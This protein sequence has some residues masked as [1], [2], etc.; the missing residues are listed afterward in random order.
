MQPYV[1]RPDAGGVLTLTKGDEVARI[2]AIP[3]IGEGRVIDAVEVLGVEHERLQSYAQRAGEIYRAMCAG[4]TPETINLVAGHLFVDGALL[5]AV[6]GS[7]RLL[8]VGQA[9]GVMAAALPSTPQYIA[10]GHIHQ[11]Q[12]LRDAPAPAA[13][14]GSLLQLD[15]GERG[16]QKVVRIVDARPGRPVEQRAVPLTQGRPLVELAGTLD[17]LALRAGEVDG[18]YVRVAL[19]VER[20]QPGL[21]QR[22]RELIP[23][24]VD[25]RLEYDRRPD[26]A[27][28]PRAERLS[29]PELFALY[30]RT[31]HGT[32]PSPELL[33]LF[34]ELLDEAAAEAES[35]VGVP[36]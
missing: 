27:P 15:F 20:P 9:Y 23:L 17:E 35:A 26:D 6:D 14:A 4:F 5:A 11:P 7:E 19:R 29:P 36:A 34:G 22:V 28:P 25:V 10:L 1:R 31:Q 30:Y 32:D 21:A 18:A 13:Y 2:A 3:W 8:H 33:A 24:A 12:E 16:Q